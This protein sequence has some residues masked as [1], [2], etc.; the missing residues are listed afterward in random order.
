MHINANTSICSDKLVLVPYCKHHVLT[1]HEWMKDPEIQA[2]TASEPLTLEEEYGMQ[3]SWRKD[4]DKL[5]FIITLP[6]TEPGEHKEGEMIGDVN[7]FISQQDSDDSDDG[8][9]EFIGELELMIATKEHRGKG[10]GPA[11]ILMFLWYIVTHQQDILNEYHGS[12]REE[13]VVGAKQ[14]E[15]TFDYFAVKIGQSNEKSIKLFESLGFK[16]VQEESNYFG[17]Y[18]LRLQVT[19]DEVLGML[20]RYGLDNVDEKR[21]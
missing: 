5:T 13:A 7:L 19:R 21:Y 15:N 9:S 3:S 2:A 4:G 18:E 14:A 12:K 16:K 11:A 20:V 6:A 10:Y 8:G 1:Y 17:E